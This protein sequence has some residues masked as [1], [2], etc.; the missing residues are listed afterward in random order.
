MIILLYFYIIKVYNNHNFDNIQKKYLRVIVMLF[1]ISSLLF[2]IELKIIRVFR[3]EEGFIPSIV[4]QLALIL[5]SATIMY[6]YAYINF[7]LLSIILSSILFFIIAEFA[8][9]AVQLGFF[10]DGKPVFGLTKLYKFIP[11]FTLLIIL[12]SYFMYSTSF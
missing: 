12:L 6:K 9:T 7:S 10:K 1:F 11:I 3:K 2:F 4:F 5:F 8:V